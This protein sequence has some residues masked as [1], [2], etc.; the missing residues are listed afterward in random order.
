MKNEQYDFVYQDG[1]IKSDSVDAALYFLTSGDFL[2]RWKTNTKQHPYQSKEKP[3]FQ[4][5]CLS[6]VDVNSAFSH[7]EIDTGWL[8]EGVIRTGFGPGGRWC[9]KVIEPRPI[10][11]LL[12]ELPTG[13]GKARDRK[14]TITPPRL[15]ML[16]MNT[17]FSLFA[18]AGPFTPNQK[19][20]YPPFPN[21]NGSGWI[22]MGDNKM[23]EAFPEN[24][25]AAWE[26]FLDAPF[27]NHGMNGKS[28]KHPDD[29]RLTLLENA[30]KDEYPVSDLQ[31]MNSTIGSIID[32]ITHKGQVD[33]D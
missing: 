20:F 10:K 16:G 27:N 8:P 31:S 7:K 11:I 30:G 21:I 22:C 1:I 25:A 32:N 17:H 3:I 4:S 14:I 6:A 28:K 33:D 26:L 23:P 24:M 9:V 15:V 19:A 18:L 29:I 5:K 13:T 2:L 12:E